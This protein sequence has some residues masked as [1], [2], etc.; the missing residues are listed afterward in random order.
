MEPLFWNLP[1]WSPLAVPIFPGAYR[2][3]HAISE[4]SAPNCKGIKKKEINVRTST[5]YVMIPPSPNWRDI[6][7]SPPSHRKNV[8]T[9]PRNFRLNQRNQCN[10]PP[11][12]H[13]H[14]IIDTLSKKKNVKLT[15]LFS[16][17][18]NILMTKS[19]CFRK[20]VSKLVFFIFIESFHDESKEIYDK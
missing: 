1:G 18:N 2:P 19:S 3:V 5:K 11:Q 16:Q 8:V 6:V 20:K 7:I 14:G 4:V 17:T 12:L 13:F 10:A 15:D 9:P